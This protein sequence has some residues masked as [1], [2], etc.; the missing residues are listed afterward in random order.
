MLCDE[1]LRDYET[2]N[3]KIDCGQLTHVDLGTPPVNIIRDMSKIRSC[4]NSF[5]IF[6]V[7]L[8]GLIALADVCNRL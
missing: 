7:L 4:S 2:I 8:F 5:V 1:H 3:R 6:P